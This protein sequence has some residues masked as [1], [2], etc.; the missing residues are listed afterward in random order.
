MTR[1]S[2]DYC[3]A[4]WDPYV[5]KHIKALEKVNRRAARVVYNRRWR[6]RS[7]SPTGLLKELQWPSLEA[8]RYQQ[9]MCLMY[10]ISHGKIAVPPT[11]L[12]LKASRQR[13]GH[14]RQYREIKR[15][16]TI[17][18]VRNSFYNRSIPQWNILPANTVEASDIDAFRSGLNP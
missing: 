8:R 7:V 6:D 4:V 18:N 1:S 3:A 5:G 12:V 13:R 14:N 11:H 2:L 10:K 9:R 15:K 16:G 17:D